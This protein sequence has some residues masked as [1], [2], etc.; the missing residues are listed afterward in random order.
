MSIRQVEAP[1]VRVSFYNCASYRNG[2]L[3]AS[4]GATILDN[5]YFAEPASYAWHC[6]WT[7]WM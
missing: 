5:P 1:T 2:W 4:R 6:G 7:D 3:A